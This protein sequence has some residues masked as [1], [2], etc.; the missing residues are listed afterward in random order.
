MAIAGEAELDCCHGD[1][2]L[3]ELWCLALSGLG[4]VIFAVLSRPD[5]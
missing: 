2:D 4:M 5:R 3:H 1:W